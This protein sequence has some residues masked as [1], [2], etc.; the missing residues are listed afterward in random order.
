MQKFYQQLL[1]VVFSFLGLAAMAQPSVT[2]TYPGGDICSGDNAIFQVEVNQNG[3]SLTAPFDVF[4]NVNNGPALSVQYSTTGTQNIIVNNVTMESTLTVDS[5]VD[6]NGTV[7]TYGAESATILAA[8]INPLPISNSFTIV[9][10]NVAEED[11]F[12]LA[13]DF[14][15]TPPFEVFFEVDDVV[16]TRTIANNIDT[17]KFFELG[18]NDVIDT[19]KIDF[20]KIEDANGCESDAAP[21]NL[22]NITVNP[23]PEVVSYTR[24]N[25][26]NGGS[27]LN[28][29]YCE[30]D[31]FNI[32]VEV[33]G[34]GSITG[35]YDVVF[36]EGAAGTTVVDDAAFSSA[37]VGGAV[38]GNISFATN[39][40]SNNIDSVRIDF[41]QLVSEFGGGIMV[42]NNDPRDSTD[43]TLG[44]PD[45]YQERAL[46]A[47]EFNDASGNLITEIC[48]EAV[49]NVD[50]DSLNTQGAVTYNISFN[51]V[52]Y[53]NV[54]AGA[55]ELVN[56]QDSAAYVIGGNQVEVLQIQDEVCTYNPTQNHIDNVNVNANPTVDLSGPSALCENDIYT[57]TLQYTG[58]AN[59][60]FTYRI[61]DNMGFNY[62]FPQLVG[63]NNGTVN[64]D[65]ND[66][67]GMGGVLASDVTY[68]IIAVALEDGNACTQNEAELNESV[69]FQYKSRPTASAAFNTPLQLCE[70]EA[71]E[72]AFTLTGDAPFTITLDS[73]SN[74]NNAGP[75]SQGN[76]TYTTNATNG[77]VSL[78]PTIPNNADS[79]LITYDILEIED[80]D[81]CGNTFLPGAN[82]VSNSVTVYQSP[83]LQDITLAEDT[84]CNTDRDQLDFT[85]SVDP[86]GGSGDYTVRGTI[87]DNLGGSY[88]FETT[89]GGSGSPFT[90]NIDSVVTPALL[91]GRTYTVTFTELEDERNTSDPND[92]CVTPIT[93]EE[94]V[95]YVYQLPDVT[96]FDIVDVD[97]IAQ[98]I[99]AICFGNDAKLLF[100]FNGYGN[101]LITVERNSVVNPALNGTFDVEYLGLA[102][103]PQFTSY[104]DRD[105]LV[106]PL[107]SVTYEVVNIQ[108]TDNAVS[109]S[110]VEAVGPLT[111]DVNDVPQAEI[112]LNTSEVCNDGVDNQV[113]VTVT[114]NEGDDPTGFDFDIV[115]EGNTLSRQI[116]NPIPRSRTFPPITVTDSGYVYLRNIVAQNFPDCEGLDDSVFVNV[117]D[118][119]D[120]TLLTPADTAVCPGEQAG[121]RVGL[122][123]VA[124]FEV[125]FLAEDGI[126]GSNTEV[127]TLLQAEA[128]N[129]VNN[130]EVFIPISG[131]SLGGDTAFTLTS[132][133][134]DVCTNATPT[135]DNSRVVIIRNRAPQLII[136]SPD[137]A[138]FGTSYPLTTEVSGG[139]DNDFGLPQEINIDYTI[140]YKNGGVFSTGT[141]NNVNTTTQL[142]NT[143]EM[144]SLTEDTTFVLDVVSDATNGCVGTPG[145]E[146]DVIVLDEIAA[147]ITAPDTI[148]NG[149][150][151]PVTISLPDNIDFQAQF[152]V[153]GATVTRNGVRNGDV[154]T[155]G[156]GGGNANDTIIL[157]SVAYQSGLACNTTINDTVTGFEQ[158]VP[159]ADIRVNQNNIQICQFTDATFEVVFTGGTGT[160]FLDYATTNGNFAGTISGLAGETKTVTVPFL[161]VG[162]Y[163]FV[164]TRVYTQASAAKCDGNGAAGN[165]ANVTV[166]QAPQVSFSPNKLTACDNEPVTFLG[167]FTQAPNSGATQYEITYEINGEGNQ[168]A[169]L[170]PDGNDEA[171]LVISRVGDYNIVLKTIQ[172]V[173]G[174]GVQCLSGI[175]QNFDISVNPRPTVAFTGDATICEQQST[176]LFVDLEG[177]AP[178][179]VTIDNFGTFSTSQDTTLSVS[180]SQT[181]TYTV[182]SVTDASGDGCASAI[183][184]PSVTVTVTEKPDVSLTLSSNPICAGQNTDIVLALTNGTAPEYEVQYQVNN[185][186]VIT[187]PNPTVG[188][189]LNITLPP[190]NQDATIK[191]V[192]IT[193]NSNPACVYTDD[194]EV[195]LE[196]REV[197][198]AT[199]TLS[200]DEVC[201]GSDVQLTLEITG[202]NGKQIN[203]TVEDELN[204]VIQSGTAPAGSII[205]LPE[206]EN[207][208]TTKT[209]S[210]TQLA[211]V[212][213][214][215]ACNNATES[216][217]VIVNPTPTIDL[218]GGGV[219]CQDN[220]IPFTVEY[221]T[222]AGDVFVD[223]RSPETNQNVNLP[224]GT[225]GNSVQYTW[226]PNDTGD[227]T[228]GVVSITAV[229]PN[230]VICQNTLN[231]PADLNFS[232]RPKPTAKLEASSL[233]IVN[234]GET[235][236]IFS[237]TGFV[238]A[239]SG[240]VEV[241]Y[242]ANGVPQN[243]DATLQV[244][245]QNPDTSIITVNPSVTTTYCITDVTQNSGA[246]NGGC[247]ISPNQCITVDVVDNKT[248]AISGDESICLSEETTLFFSFDNPTPA[249]D[250]VI[251][252]N[253]NSVRDTLFGVQDNVPVTY[254]PSVSGSLSLV[255]AEVTTN[256]FASSVTDPNEFAGVAT[257]EVAETKTVRLV[258]DTTI[259]EGQN[260]QFTVIMEGTGEFTIPF[261]ITPSGS[262]RI[263]T[264]SQND[265]PSKRTVIASELRLGENIV[266]Y[267]GTVTN[268]LNNAC[269]IEQLGTA[270]IY[271]RP[272]PTGDFEL[273]P[274]EPCEGVS[275]DIIL[276]AQPDTGVFNVTYTFYNDPV[277]TTNSIADGGVLETHSITQNGAVIL[278]N[279]EYAD[280]PGCA[281]NTIVRRDLTFKDAPKVAFLTNDQDICNGQSLDVVVRL[282]EV[283]R[284]PVTFTY[285]DGTQ[286]STIV[287][288]NV[289]NLL[290]TVITLQPTVTTTYELVEVFDANTPSCEGD[291]AV[292]Q[293][294]ITIG[295]GAPLILNEFR[296]FNDTICDGEEVSYVV[297]VNGDLPMTAYFTGTDGG[298]PFTFTRTL[299]NTG[300]NLFTFNPTNGDISLCLDRIVD[301]ENCEL[302]VDQ[303]EEVQVIENPTLTYTANRTSLCLGDSV[304]LRISVTAEDSVVARFQATNPAVLDTNYV[305]SP[306][307]QFVWMK[308]KQAGDPVIITVETVSYLRPRG[309]CITE[310]LL[311]RSYRIF[312]TPTASIE[313]DPGL[314]DTV[315]CQNSSIQLNFQSPA[316]G[317]KTIFFENSRGGS[318]FV[319]IPAG[320]VNGSAT[321]VP[322]VGTNKYYITQV[323]RN[324]NG[325]I[326]D[327]PGMDTVTV[328]VAPTPTVQ[329]STTNNPRCLNGPS[330]VITFNFT[331]NGPFIFDYSDGTNTFTR[332]A[333]V[334]NDGDGRLDVQVTV[335]PGTTTTY[336]VTRIEDATGPN[337]CVNN[338]PNCRT[339]SVN[340]Q[341]EAELFNGEDEVCEGNCVSL[342]YFLRG[343]APLDV[344]FSFSGTAPGLPNV[345]GD[346]VLTGLSTG[347]NTFTLC[348]PEPRDYIVVIDSIADSNTPQCTSGATI[349]FAEV[350]I[351]PTP[352]VQSF[353]IDFNQLCA[354]DSATI[355][356]FPEPVGGNFDYPYRI[357]YLRNGVQDSATI[358]QAKSFFK[359][360]PSATTTYRLRRILNLNTGCDSVYA[361]I[362]PFTETLEIFPNPEIDFQVNPSN[363]CVGDNFNLEV[364][365]TGTAS[366]LFDVYV[367]GTVIATNQAVTPPA[368]ASGNFEA[369]FTY[370]NAPLPA[371]GFNRS[372][373]TIQNLRD[374]SAANNGTP[375][376][377]I[378]EPTD[379]AFFQVNPEATAN[380]DNTNTLTVC[381]GDSLD[382]PI[383]VTGSGTV[384]VVIEVRDGGTNNLLRTDTITA[385]AYSGS[386]IYSDGPTTSVRYDIVNVF[387]RTAGVQCP[388]LVGNSLAVNVR[389][390]PRMTIDVDPET[391][392]EN[393]EVQVTY[394]IDGQGPFDFVRT[395]RRAD[396]TD[397]VTEF[398]SE[399]SPVTEFLRLKDTAVVFVDTIIR[400]QTP[401]CFNTDS[402]GKRIN[403]NPKAKATHLTADTAVCEG[404]QPGFRVRLEGQG[405]ITVLYRRMPSGPIQTYTNLAGEY[406]IPVSQGPGT[407]ARWQIVSV[408]DESNP[409]C[410]E[411]S[412][413]GFTDITVTTAPSANINGEFEVCEGGQAAINIEIDGQFGDQ[414]TV[415]YTGRVPGG[416]FPDVTGTYTN[417]PG[418][419]GFLI[420]DVDTTRFY[421]VDSVA[422]EGLAPSCV[423][424]ASDFPSVDTAK[425]FVRP[426]PQVSISS[427]QL[428]VCRFED[429]D[430]IFDFPFDGPYNMTYSINGDPG[431]TVSDVDDGFTVTEMDPVANTTIEVLSLL[432]RDIPQCVD[433]DVASLTVAVNDTLLVNIVDTLCNDSATGFRFVV[434]IAAGKA[435]TYFFR[436]NTGAIASVALEAP[437]DTLP[438]ILNGDFDFS[439][440]DSSGCPSVDFV[441]SYECECISQSGRFT[442]FTDT[443]FTCEDIV[444][445]ATSLFDG[446]DE[447]LDANDV[448]KF[449][450][451]DNAGPNLGT[452][453]AVSNT[454]TFVKGGLE[455]NTTYY[456]S[457]LVADE[458]P[459]TA[460]GFDRND[461]CLSISRGVP[462]QWIDRST[463]EIEILPNDSGFY[464]TD[465]VLN[466]RFK[467]TSPGTPPN[468]GDFTVEWNDGTGPDRSGNFFGADA[469]IVSDNIASAD[470]F[471]EIISFTDA[472][473]ANNC[474]TVINNFEP[475]TLEALP[476]ADF[477]GDATLCG[478]EVFADSEVATFTAEATGNFAYDWTFENGTPDDGDQAT[479]NVQYDQQGL[480]DVT[481]R[482]TNQFG[483]VDSTSNDIDVSIATK[484]DIQAV[485]RPITPVC[486]DDIIEFSA[487]N[488]NAT[489]GDPGQN[490]DDIAW[491]VDGALDQIDDANTWQAPIFDEKRQY[492]VVVENR[493]GPG[494]TS[495]DTVL[496]TVRGPEVDLPLNFGPIC[497]GDSLNLSV[498]NPV[499][500]DQV[501]W[502]IDHPNTQDRTLP[503][504]FRT[505][506]FIQPGEEADRQI[507][508]LATLTSSDG[509]IR[510]IDFT[511][512]VNDLYA[513]IQ[514]TVIQGEDTIVDPA[515]YCFG[516]SDD[517][518]IV[519]GSLIPATG[520]D[521]TYEWVIGKQGIIDTDANP[522]AETLDSLGRN[523]IKLNLTNTANGCTYTTDSLIFEILGLPQVDIVTDNLGGDTIC[524][525]VDDI[526]L[527]ASDLDETP[528]TRWAWS[529]VGLPNDSVFADNFF[530]LDTNQVDASLRSLAENTYVF[531][532]E[533]EDING[534]VST[535]R[536]TL[537]YFEVE[538][539][540][541]I[542]KFQDLD[543]TFALGYELA[544]D[545][546]LGN[547]AF[548][549]QWTPEDGV[550]FP[551]FGL[552]DIFTLD[553]AF[554]TLTV[555]DIYGCFN[556]VSVDVNINLIREATVDVP[557]AFTPN[558]DGI[559][560]EIFPDGWALLEIGEFKV[561]NR[562]GEVLWVGTGTKEEAAWDGTYK[563]KIQPVDTYYYTVSVSTRLGT[564]IIE[565]GEFNIIR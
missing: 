481:L 250:V 22:G 150:D 516:S 517:V 348:L 507:T 87:T 107:D 110:R 161:P 79:V 522:A 180:P 564:Q 284:Y 165:T 369:T 293:E 275:Q 175:N 358:T 502:N 122:T 301:N 458:R 397:S 116:L 310:D 279:I 377:C 30:G 323:S 12:R 402:V 232:V 420:E 545:Y 27:A 11:T 477:T 281:N 287:F 4:Y 337:A 384:F 44:A 553:D 547:P 315:V 468:D 495:R 387:S 484:P 433:E 314:E 200:E 356:V 319:T 490:S 459:F 334:D 347:L 443:L 529:S 118:L 6:D 213:A 102:N 176:D 277:E 81:N 249:Y 132:V 411:N 100:D 345:D 24:L 485:G 519:P 316:N 425:I 147:S 418:N 278:R 457:A 497:S 71:A 218:T 189:N 157:L 174:N 135:D 155:F 390:T 446:T 62:T 104:T 520:Q 191:L 559:N 460:N 40:I 492:V 483:C 362:N 97:N 453:L 430:F 380:F 372:F 126:G 393:D 173:D 291:V 298:I 272:T 70:G 383:T 91:A 557:D 31:Q 413:R 518:S 73:I 487:P 159:A 206:Q 317:E 209:Y 28:N 311:P 255:I 479:E 505:S 252:D 454:P 74:V 300:V 265:S 39:T 296:T 21:I 509:C 561:Y 234:G 294:S 2:A 185:D 396:G 183:G 491:Y 231:L 376:N 532:V 242:T 253:A 330:S 392:C 328:E 144:F 241:S 262:Q 404:E 475:Y 134:D 7:F 58:Q 141:F 365:V 461:R 378:T 260:G 533:V 414:V 9:N 94:F 449:V 426:S 555:N 124:P 179:T 72:L 57:L 95:F 55:N 223:L 184:T 263:F 429:I 313:I 386:V 164:R 329:I 167:S 36:F 214:A 261:A 290:D 77:T 217:T 488:L 401:M 170:T 37:M 273:D 195:D 211:Y 169:I 283:D 61:T 19:Y 473:N 524:S 405:A 238:G 499:D 472:D 467:F 64:I 34:N 285:N 436:D 41:S 38:V 541:S 151:L 10:A 565:R 196:V 530:N 549:Y 18:I 199:L 267:N 526:Q 469:D 521:V 85:V 539:P 389:N 560:D 139:N 422:Y 367:N 398:L 381:E 172:E 371:P 471:I 29:T 32:E 308:P 137:V 335:A 109:C 202:R 554:Y 254:T 75:Q 145:Q 494:C 103:G 440:A 552:T 113:E 406:F 551:N 432:Y 318:G 558:G 476:N 146:F 563:G 463:L 470:G 240:D 90:F 193:D 339:I 274:V 235:D 121:F 266:D 84:V 130:R 407:V 288:N 306:G 439:V 523:S 297:D 128:G 427:P 331:G 456:I 349:G 514:H 246:V 322:Q 388:G 54:S 194:S 204:N 394:T 489:N 363:V 35:T 269:P 357:F 546:A 221:L 385:L 302:N 33:T 391:A 359:V 219:Y 486:L 379:T 248:A 515:Q 374:N 399:F 416:G 14:T 466:Y 276:D 450:L 220:A 373:V 408:D 68:E 42:E 182:S 89:N 438:E 138:C 482:V 46:T 480:W 366:F 333:S 225:A 158:L 419:Y 538:D 82:S 512:P 96:A 247:S 123:G 47:T 192:Q 45:I 350:I 455:T 229:S 382:F 527:L 51:G 309:G 67:D 114:I 417:F 320:S 222:G 292:G 17:V 364:E 216:A 344:R 286:D 228:L 230:N 256:N 43:F 511:V 108:S 445:D 280:M 268:S 444:A 8:Q 282:T 245:I 271:V 537:H 148:C 531:D 166:R 56:L 343:R 66:Y 506:Y 338:S 224:S 493:F 428:D 78:F 117:N 400:R 142:R 131:I 353:D 198:E 452:V 187:H 101:T 556:P 351:N 205:N 233:T 105:F 178:F 501:T 125:S 562:N 136:T 177:T 264:A 243:P 258:G 346:T 111:L 342:Q 49:L 171:E 88:T 360:A 3:S 548:E 112:S 210:V 99:D 59:F 340:Q 441:D 354:G 352:S 434:D 510:N 154:L 295:V 395:I 149:D 312:S 513:E 375:T 16:K 93:G 259:C 133:S 181:T 525:G 251:V 207:L 326:C 462:V 163:S 23:K 1:A 76:V 465:N 53:S 303:C 368:N 127:F 15:G 304:R 327:A 325:T 270:R 60:D 120:V 305:L 190:F 451:H 498:A 355:T 13:A 156:T 168:T 528:D 186:P 63:V 431:I 236:L 50:I 435:G 92:D 324:T 415:Y 503:T 534:C 421:T 412:G 80:A 307:T 409:R 86:I 20:V 550:E 227:V 496:F 119:P 188:G 5:I 65:P 448:A 69:S 239:G 361:P 437:R 289:N 332:T 98:S 129:Y 197:P 504:P 212:D 299:N 143:P 244:N 106:A 500:V 341:P 474:Y 442:N 160:I 26:P 201:E 423:I 215:P 140:S 115:Y 257:I 336:C 464:C 508:G 237:G 152:N 542:P 162:T 403:V 543:T 370:P 540:T 153:N 208:A 203:Y 447:Q 478:D 226:T 48:N 536:D 424:P 535:V 52:T 544:V 83:T 321:V 410:V 25:G